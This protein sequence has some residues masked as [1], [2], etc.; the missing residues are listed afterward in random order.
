M[1]GTYYSA[2]TKSDLAKLDYQKWWPGNAVDFVYAMASTGG[3]NEPMLRDATDGVISFYD[4]ISD[5]AFHALLAGA[6]PGL[7]FRSSIVAHCRRMPAT[8][9]TP[10]GLHCDIRYHRDGP[11]ALNFWTPLDPAGEQF[12]TSGLEVWPVGYERMISYFGEGTSALDDDGKFS[13]S[14]IESEF[15]PGMSTNIDVGDIMVFTSWTLHRTYV[16]QNVRADR[17]S[18]EIRLAADAFP[19][20]TQIERTENS[21]T[22]DSGTARRRRSHFRELLSTAKRAIKSRVR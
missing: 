11:F 19:R 15:G 6:F 13:P 21:G 9:S 18:A 2:L 5:P 14:S 4:L 16:P 12:G 20:Q 10:I 17:L 22:V 3:V 8:R 7:T 1:A